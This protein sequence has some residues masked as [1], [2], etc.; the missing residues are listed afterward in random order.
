MIRSAR[1]WER[2]I[3]LTVLLFAARPARATIDYSVSVAHP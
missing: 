2:T 1:N 3:A